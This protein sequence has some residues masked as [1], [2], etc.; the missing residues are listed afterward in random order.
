MINKRILRIIIMILINSCFIEC[1]YAKIFVLIGP[2]GAGKSTLMNKFLSSE[3]KAEEL[4]SY[5]TR[6]MRAQEKNAKDYFFVSKHEYMQREQNN[7]FILSTV[8]HDNLYG[9]SKKYISDVIREDRNLICSLNTEAA[10]KLKSLY[11]TKV[12]TIFVAPPS[13]NELKNRLI[14]RGEEKISFNVRLKNA[15]NE[16]KEKDS[17]DYKIV[18]DNI[19]ESLSHLK[20]IF[21]SE[22]TLDLIVKQS[23]LPLNDSKL[24]RAMSYNIRMAPCAEDEKTENFWSY[25]LPKINMIFNKYTPD[26]VGVQEVSLS[27]M[28]S[29]EKS[30]YNVPYKFIG[31]YPTKKPI[32]SGLGIIYNS[33]KLVLLSKLH[34]SWLNESQAQA[35][36]PAWDG[37]SYERYVIYAKFKN[38]V[39]GNDFWFMTTHF[40]HLGMKA[41]Q[42]SAKI[43]MSIAENLD[44][45]ALITGDFN[46]FPQAGGK[47]LY[48]FLSS[49][50]DTIRDSAKIA[51]LVFGVP[52][53][54]IGW[55]YDI[56]KQRKGYAKY[57]FIFV[58]GIS[59]VL[60][61]GIIDDRI[62]DSS[63]QKQVY[64]SDHRPVLSD[65]DI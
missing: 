58:K 6:P 11:G 38:I 17:F 30:H 55:D 37:S 46:C 62:W 35:D 29:L 3:F 22:S 7:E 47:K 16:I 41:R 5:T 19:D 24:I 36:A 10:K 44:A 25:R 42:E 8:V 31:K 15:K 51:H 49:N 64:P 48:K 1:A 32:E 4:I 52:G 50:F 14:K 40:D 28:E 27:Q 63:F 57:D 12:V 61:H 20:K 9:I 33:Q 23:V 43:V 60:Q 39:T 13:L 21:F 56:Y 53:S 54:W 18:N 34:T 2:S 65:L 59:E 45:P 26:I